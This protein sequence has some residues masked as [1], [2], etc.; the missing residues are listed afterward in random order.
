VGGEARGRVLHVYMY[1]FHFH[2]Y[3]VI[4][5]H[6]RR[7]ACARDTPSLYT[8]LQEGG[9]TRSFV[10]SSSGAR[11]ACWSGDELPRG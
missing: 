1:V 11:R 9:Q 10:G 8:R 4:I 6:L 3:K 7:C 2:I 5:N